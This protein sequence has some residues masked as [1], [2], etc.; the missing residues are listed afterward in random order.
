MTAATQA[1]LSD[2]AP[3]SIWHYVIPLGIRKLALQ[4]HHNLDEAAHTRRNH[5]H[6]Q[7][8]L[9]HVMPMQQAD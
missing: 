9:Q 7:V 1:S 3:S 8:T 6:I 5:V 4:L 2:T